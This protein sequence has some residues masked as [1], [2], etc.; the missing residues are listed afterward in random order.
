MGDDNLQA[1]VYDV[2]VRLV[3]FCESLEGIVSFQNVHLANPPSSGAVIYVEGGQY[4]PGSQFGGD[5]FPI[6]RV[7][8]EEH[9]A[10]Y[11]PARRSSAL[12]MT[13]QFEELTEE[14]QEFLIAYARSY[15]RDEPGE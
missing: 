11:D 4:L 1:F 12:S 10:S 5:Y 9:Y 13:A 14:G 3:G 6:G 2:D 8:D 15:F 7:S